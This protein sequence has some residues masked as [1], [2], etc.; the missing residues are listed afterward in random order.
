MSISDDD[1]SNAVVVFL[2]LGSASSPR[3]NRDDLAGKFGPEKGAELASQVTALVHEMNGL[4]IDWSVQSLESAGDI[5]RKEMHRRH[6][7]L[8]DK[9]LRALAWKFTFDWR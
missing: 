9:A 4:A 6:P 5:I 7:D 1:L 2:G 3:Q 8:S